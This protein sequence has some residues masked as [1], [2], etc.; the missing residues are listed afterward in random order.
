MGKPT[1]LLSLLLLV[2]TLVML[3]VFHVLKSGTTSDAFF[4][5]AVNFSKVRS[6]H[7]HTL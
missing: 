1:L 7:M 6:T 5:C 3:C 4:S 2:T